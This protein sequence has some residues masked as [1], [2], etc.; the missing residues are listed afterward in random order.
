MPPGQPQLPTTSTRWIVRAVLAALVLAA[1]ANS[2]GA[3]LIFD[4]RAIVLEDPRL[5]AVTLEHLSQILTRNYWWPYTETSLYRPFTTL[6]YLFNYSVLG[7]SDH[8]AGYHVVNLLIHGANVLLLFAIAER[9][10]HRLWPAFALAAIWSVHPVLTEA[11]T[12]V[13]GRADLLATLGVLGALWCHIHARDTS[14]NGRR[15]WWQA[16]VAAAAT[17]AWRFGQ[18]RSRRLGAEQPAARR[19]EVQ[20]IHGPPPVGRRGGA[21]APGRALRAGDDRSRRRRRTR[22]PPGRP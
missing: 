7:N 10:I 5:R 14:G 21:P 1:F 3:G 16:G 17:V 2:L 9:I 22:C 11:V 6:T 8:A 19:S 20:S 18:R 4:N 12:N 15:R 13:V